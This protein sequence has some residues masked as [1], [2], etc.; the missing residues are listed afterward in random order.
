MLITPCLRLKPIPR[1]IDISS[2]SSTTIQNTSFALFFLS[3]MST[4]AVGQSKFF[5]YVLLI[6]YLFSLSS[7]QVSGNT[8]LLASPAVIHQSDSQVNQSLLC[9]FLLNA[10]GF[11]Q[12]TILV[13]LCCSPVSI[14]PGALIQIS[15]LPQAVEKGDIEMIN[16]EDIM[17]VDCEYRQL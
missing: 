10:S 3:V 2:H 17:D 16:V 1:S 12:A 5:L 13:T 6:C 7:P 4:T 11:P 8:N 9:F 14:P 15:I